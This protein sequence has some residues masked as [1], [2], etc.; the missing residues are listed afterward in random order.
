MSEL[1]FKMLQRMKQSVSNYEPVPAVH[2][3]GQSVQ[4]LVMVPL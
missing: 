2:I 4:Q 1:I 3:S